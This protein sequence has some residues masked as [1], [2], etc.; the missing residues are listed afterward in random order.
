MSEKKRSQ[1]LLTCSKCSKKAPMYDEATGQH[2]FCP[3]SDEKRIVNL[4]MSCKRK[5]LRKKKD[6]GLPEFRPQ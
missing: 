3:A 5:S 6:V 1:H 2:N 4:C